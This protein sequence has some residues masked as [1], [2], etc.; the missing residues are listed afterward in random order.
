ML[1]RNNA[2][3]FSTRTPRPQSYKPTDEGSDESLTCLADNLAAP[4]HQL[5]WGA[6]VKVTVLVS[7]TVTPEPQHLHPKSSNHFQLCDMP[8]TASC[9]SLRDSLL[10]SLQGLLCSARFRVW[11]AQSTTHPAVLTPS[12]QG[13]CYVQSLPLRGRWR[14]DWLGSRAQALVLDSTEH[15]PDTEDRCQRYHDFLKGAFGNGQCS[16]VE[17]A[18]AG[19]GK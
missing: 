3:C 9:R 18:K 13:L 7:S 5:A 19:S 11:G 17:C 6:E 1:W 2:V 16:F 8:K 15:D 14:K 12:S 10:Y 4:Q